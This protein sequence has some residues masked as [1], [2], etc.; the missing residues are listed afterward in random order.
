M[1][2]LLK[3]LLM[4]IKEAKANLIPKPEGET[5]EGDVIVGFLP[6]NLRRSYAVYTA[7]QDEFGG[8][9]EAFRPKLKEMIAKS[10]RCVSPK[11]MAEAADFFLR[12]KYYEAVSKVFWYSVQEALHSKIGI[13]PSNKELAI[14]SRWRVVIQA[15]RTKSLLETIEAALQ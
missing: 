10:G 14:Y 15:K 4:L 5:G 9:W 13:I 8:V 3:G 12:Y 11:E 7:S 1:E 6:R 2:K